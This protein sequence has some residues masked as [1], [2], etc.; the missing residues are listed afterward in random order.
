MYVSIVIE[1]AIV[2]TGK[3]GGKPD[4]YHSNDVNFFHSIQIQYILAF[5]VRII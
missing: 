4:Y 1:I 3:N 2:E 5:Y